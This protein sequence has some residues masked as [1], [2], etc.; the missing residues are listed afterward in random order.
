MY[1]LSLVHLHFTLAHFKGQGQGH[2]HLDNE[3]LE[4]GDIYCNKFDY[5][6]IASRAWAFNRHIYVRSWPILKVKVKPISAMYILKMA[7]NRKH[8][9]FALKQDKT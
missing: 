5:H 3:H 4:N 2:S 7:S 8:I 9:Q 6:Q 1:W